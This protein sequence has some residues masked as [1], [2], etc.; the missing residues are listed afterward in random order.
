[1]SEMGSGR[2]TAS[3][4]VSQLRSDPYRLFWPTAN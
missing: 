1:V 3:A 4:T 2:V